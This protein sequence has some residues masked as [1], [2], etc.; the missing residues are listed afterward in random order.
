MTD[1]NLI[2]VAPETAAPK[3]NL[4]LSSASQWKQRAREDSGSFS[5]S[6]DEGRSLKPFDAANIKDSDGIMHRSSVIHSSLELRDVDWRSTIPQN[7]ATAISSDLGETVQLKTQ[8]ISLPC[9]LT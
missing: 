5:M 2:Q 3:K 9:T 6:K 4:F 8:V 1:V 7:I